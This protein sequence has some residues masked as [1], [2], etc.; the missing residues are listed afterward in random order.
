MT[1]ALARTTPTALA[2][3]VVLDARS[4]AYARASRSQAT[5]TAYAADWRAFLAWC[6]RESQPPLPA[7]PEAV[8]AYL[9]WL[10]DGVEEPDH[11]GTPRIVRRTVSTLARRKAAIASAHAVAA[12]ADPTRHPQVRLVWE[13]IRRQLGTAPKRKDAI[14]PTELAQM[15]HLLGSDIHGVR[16]RAMLVLG[17]CGAF[18]RSELC[19]LRVDDVTFVKQGLRIVLRRSKTDQTGAGRTVAVLAHPG[20]ALCPVE[21]LRA[22]KYEAGVQDGPLFRGVDRWGRVLRGA[23]HPRTWV[24]R[25]KAVATQVG[26]DPRRVGGHSLRAGFVTAALAGGAQPFQV[27]DVTGHKSF[28]VLRRYIREA[29]LWKH[30]AG[31]YLTL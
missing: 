14:T 15:V 7:P 2:E 21:C 20:A 18:R 6:E 8:A 27:M 24:D 16:D 5:L 13:G 3:P 30:N 1:R 31:E 28:E 10:A 9:S 12:H 4:Q 25:L 22:W 17:L 26:M 23:I 11:W 29:S 19:G